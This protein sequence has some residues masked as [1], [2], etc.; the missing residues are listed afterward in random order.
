MFYSC[1]TYEKLKNAHKYFDAEKK[2]LYIPI[3]NDYPLYQKKYAHHINESLEYA[4]YYINDDELIEVTPVSIRLR[5]KI[6]NT[7]QR[8]K[9]DAKK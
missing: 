5:K 8:K 2:L 4:L 1:Y 7:E 9:F 3:G 6:L